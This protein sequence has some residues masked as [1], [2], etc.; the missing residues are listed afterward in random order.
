MD[1][2]KTLATGLWSIYDLKSLEFLKEKSESGNKLR[3]SIASSI[4]SDLGASKLIE[5]GL[6]NDASKAKAYDA[7][8]PDSFER[9]TLTMQLLSD[10]NALNDTFTTAFLSALGK[11]KPIAGDDMNKL[12]S[13]RGRLE[14]K[15][16]LTKFVGVIRGIKPTHGN[17]KQVE[18]DGVKRLREAW[19]S[20]LGGKSSGAGTGTGS[21]TSSG[22][23]RGTNSQNAS[24]SDEDLSKRFFEANIPGIGPVG[25]D[26]RIQRG[27]VENAGG[28]QLDT[29][30]KQRPQA[31][32][33]PGTDNFSAENSDFVAIGP[34]SVNTAKKTY[35]LTLPIADS[36]NVET[37]PQENLQSDALFEAFSWVPDGH[38]LGVEN[39]LHALNRQSEALRFGMEPLYEPRP[40]V[41]YAHPRPL[42][43]QFTDD[44]G[45][46]ALI[47]EY[48]HK[49]RNI[50]EEQKTTSTLGKRPL[51]VM[52]DDYHQHDSAKQL[53]TPHKASWCR[54]VI[55]PVASTLKPAIRAPELST[56]SGNDSM[57]FTYQGI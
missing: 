6:A 47:K 54:P 1:V 25:P 53:P 37:S 46:Q 51:A 2:T 22:S 52:E 3:I 7:T 28:G 8:L 23:R 20:A 48:T 17:I 57:L 13:A 32:G 4:N 16:K 26:G 19:S 45:A 30:I 35:R 41:E 50:R 34:Q 15:Q 40:Q 21:G 36:Q 29:V 14:L 31:V 33:K 56:I 55:A 12:T 42:P 18:S 24:A 44:V 49:V 38:G 10:A 27:I 5:K 43:G 39:K 9:F 11:T